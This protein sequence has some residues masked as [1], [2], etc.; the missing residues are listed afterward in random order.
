MAAMQFVNGTLSHGARSPLPAA[1]MS[2]P[3]R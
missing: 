3:R 2:P 1:G